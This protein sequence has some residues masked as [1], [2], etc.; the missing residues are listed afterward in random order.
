MGL[1]TLARKILKNKTGSGQTKK[2]Q[3]PGTRDPRKSWHLVGG[4]KK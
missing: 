1:R 3:H 4:E 2:G